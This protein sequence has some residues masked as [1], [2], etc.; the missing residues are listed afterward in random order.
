VTLP[1]AHVL[2]RAA[3]AV[4]QGHPWIF[5]SQIQSWEP[6]PGPGD[7]VEVLDP[8]SRGVGY[9]YANPRTTLALRLLYTPSAG[10]RG[11]DGVPDERTELFRKL[12]RARSRRRDFD[13]QT[14]A[15]RLVWSEA[16]GLPG[17]VVD[18]FGDRV[19]A[20]FLTAG[21]EKRKAWIVEWLVSHLKPRGVFERS[22]GVGRSREGLVPV[23]QWL[24]PASPAAELNAP[25]VIQEGPL[26]FWVDVV[27]GQ[28]TGFYLDQRG[29]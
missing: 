11:T 15:Y 18:C 1:R 8:Q 16:D 13:W 23:R 10:Q 24:Y 4:R 3:Q 22:E 14:D 20:Q 2:A 9:A 26:R 17:L 25:A 12:D 28:K 29:W 21:M 7:L 5:S 27:G 6:V 19:V